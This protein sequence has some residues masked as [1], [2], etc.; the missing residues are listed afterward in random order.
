M[1]YV[2]P[3]GM[4]I[5]DTDT[6]FIMQN[7]SSS[8]TLGNTKELIS[9]VG[10]TLTAY[11]RIA[12]AISGT[13][14]SLEMANEKAKNLYTNGNELSP[15]AGEKLINSLI[16]GTGKSVTYAGSQSLDSMTESGSFLNSLE[17]S[18]SK[19]YV[20]ARIKTT[21]SN[22]T[23]EYGHTVNINSNS[24]FA[25]NIS[26]IDNALNIKV[27]DTSGVRK[28]ISDDV[29]DNVLE[30]IDYFRVNE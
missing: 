20:T 16:E 5:K 15:Q 29:R 8:S 12:N 17:N 24:V 11:T 7:S 14:I 18:F 2:D 21:D 26:D 28:Q 6:T 22:N 13:N 4:E 25:G 1:R 3:D 10:C 23:K 9:A 19:V 27:N 30:R